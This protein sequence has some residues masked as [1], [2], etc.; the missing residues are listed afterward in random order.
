MNSPLELGDFAHSVHALRVRPASALRA[1]F[2]RIT[3]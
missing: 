1:F 3:F 2:E